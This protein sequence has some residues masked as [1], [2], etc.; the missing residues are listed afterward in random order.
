MKS[1]I[2]LLVLA[3]V[4]AVIAINLWGWSELRLECKADVFTNDGSADKVS[5]EDVYLL[6]R[7]PTRFVFW[8]PHGSVAIEL[9]KM[10]FSGSVFG[11]DDVEKL[12]FNKDS[13]G[14]FDG[15]LSLMSNAASIWDSQYFYDMKCK[16]R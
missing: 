14:G 11:S 5:T 6:V 12:F 16:P 13:A 3:G 1:I 9:K 2:L 10:Q 8:R 7:Y 4:A 15:S